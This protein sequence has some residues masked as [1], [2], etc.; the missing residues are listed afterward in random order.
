MPQDHSISLEAANGNLSE[1]GQVPHVQ[2]EAKRLR[3]KGNCPLNIFDLITNT[4]KPHNESRCRVRWFRML[5]L[6]LLY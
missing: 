1:S 6:V 2:I 4:S 3:I 5:L